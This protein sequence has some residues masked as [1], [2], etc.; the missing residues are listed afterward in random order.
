MTPTVFSKQGY[1]FFFFSREEPRLHVHVVSSAGEAKF[2][3]EP[4]VET[5]RV[6]RYNQQQLRHIRALVE[7][8]YDELVTAWR[9]H[10]GT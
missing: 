10:F 3:L 6:Y 8:H 1:R 5:A 7:E 9:R 2:W 4:T